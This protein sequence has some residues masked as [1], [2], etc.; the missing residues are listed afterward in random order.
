DLE[1]ASSTAAP[2]DRL[3]Y[4]RPRPPLFSLSATELTKDSSVRRPG[5]G[6]ASKLRDS[7]RLPL[8]R[9]SSGCNKS[10]E[11]FEGVHRQGRE[12]SPSPDGSQQP[13]TSSAETKSCPARA[14]REQSLAGLRPPS[15]KQLVRMGHPAAP[16]DP[17]GT[18][19][20]SSADC[21]AEL[22]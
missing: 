21:S 5:L 14:V 19:R 11:N 7:F 22:C 16:A 6:R 4:V 3:A 1:P 12:R 17:T 18:R 13:H 15:R 9:G 10:R 8:A 2:D 20:D